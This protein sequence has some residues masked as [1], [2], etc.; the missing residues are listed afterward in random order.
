MICV[1]IFLKHIGDN[2]GYEK[3]VLEYYKI[4]GKVFSFVRK[5]IH[6]NFSIFKSLADVLSIF[7]YMKKNEKR[8]GMEIHMRDLMKVAKA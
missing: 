1:D 6:K 4:Y 5:K 7:R 2:I 3:E 8:F